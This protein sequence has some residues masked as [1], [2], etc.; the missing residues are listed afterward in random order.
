MKKIVLPS[1]KLSISSRTRAATFGRDS[2][3]TVFR[4]SASSEGL[5]SEG[6]VSNSHNNAALVA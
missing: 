5:A 2:P 4:D 3:A 1:R 6:N